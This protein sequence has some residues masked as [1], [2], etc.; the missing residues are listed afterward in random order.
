LPIH[1]DDVSVRELL[2]GAVGLFRTRAQNEDIELSWQAPDISVRIDAAR[3]RQ[4]LDNLLDNALRH[5]PRG[6]RV[7]VTA[8]VEKSQRFW[9]SVADS[10][11]GFEAPADGSAPGLGLRIARSVAEGH[12][13][14][15]EIGRSEAG[16][17]VLILSASLQPAPTAT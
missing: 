7:T 2:D 15:L 17:A 5:T 8:G 14:A 13:G 6:G 11:P 12:G 1:R 16:G 3:M 10:G 4:A 9:L